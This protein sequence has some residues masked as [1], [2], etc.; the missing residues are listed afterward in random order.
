[1]G[2]VGLCCVMMP[3]TPHNYDQIV[4]LCVG[5]MKF[6]T[7]KSTL[8]SK[9]E[10]F[11]TLL[12]DN[13]SQKKVPALKDQ[14]GYFFIDR[15]GELFRHVLNY[16]RTGKL[17]KPDTMSLKQIELELDFYQIKRSGND[18][19][20]DEDKQ[21]TPVPVHTK[22]TQES[23]D[24]L[25]FTEILDRWRKEAS[26]WFETYKSLILKEITVAANNGDTSLTLPF[27]RS[28]G[29]T[30]YCSIC[31]NI[32]LPTKFVRADLW[33][34]ALVDIVQNHLNVRLSFRSYNTTVLGYSFDFVFTWTVLLDQLGQRE[35]LAE[36]FHLLN[37]WN[38]K[39]SQR[40]MVDSGCSVVR[41]NP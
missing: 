20:H 8:F 33:Q 5:G 4:K 24:Y 1:M 36:V 29:T 30:H 18:I 13:D 21:P 17:F 15:D 28:R 31:G 39:P 2:V 38:I 37:S 41:I 7:T 11:F 25:Q 32:K 16:L 14:E 27:N 26:E 22:R 6:V 35:I 9:G 19:V 23:S 40:R 3:G 10:N 12:I 34:E